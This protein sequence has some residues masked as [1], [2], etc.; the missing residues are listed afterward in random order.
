MI[1]LVRYEKN[2]VFCNFNYT[3]LVVGCC[4]TIIQSKIFKQEMLTIS[5]LL[6]E[7]MEEGLT[8]HTEDGFD[9]IARFVNPN[10]DSIKYHRK[11]SF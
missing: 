10:H 3:F 5:D 8:G 9:P 6:D 1:P 2:N 7:W 4:E 11:S